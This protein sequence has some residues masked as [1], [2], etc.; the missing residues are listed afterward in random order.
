VSVQAWNLAA[1]HFKPAQQDRDVLRVILRRIFFLILARN[2]SRPPVACPKQKPGKH[3]AHLGAGLQL[4]SINKWAESPRDPVDAGDING[5]LWRVFFQSAI[6]RK[7]NQL[8]LR[9]RDQDG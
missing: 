6:S 9:A 7:R 8:P 3:Q 4:L 1:R 2:R 5:I